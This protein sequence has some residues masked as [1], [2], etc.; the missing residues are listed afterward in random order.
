[1]PTTKA[2]IRATNK[3]IGKAY[4]RFNI[5]VPK[6]RKADVEAHVAKAGEGS[7][8]SLVNDL[9]REHIGMTEE[10]WKRKPEEGGPGG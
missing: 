2:Q 4:D 7:V 9:L 6:G 3:Y 8:N 10:E 5:V 1:M